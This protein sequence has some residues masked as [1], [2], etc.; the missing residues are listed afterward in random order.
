MNK[1]QAIAYGCTHWGWVGGCKTYF[2]IKKGYVYFMNK[3]WNHASVMKFY[4]IK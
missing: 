3:P 4:K 1:N 2:T